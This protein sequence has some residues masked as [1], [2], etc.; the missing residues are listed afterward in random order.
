M[1]LIEFAI[2]ALTFGLCFCFAFF[3]GCIISLRRRVEAMEEFVEKL[4][5]YP[6]R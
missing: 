3:L 6:Y 4:D 5:I 2:C 1:T